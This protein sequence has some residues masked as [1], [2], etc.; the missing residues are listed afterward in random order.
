VIP[1]KGFMLTIFTRNSTQGLLLAAL[2]ELVN[3]SIVST[4]CRR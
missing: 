1:I 2:E 4:D 3:S